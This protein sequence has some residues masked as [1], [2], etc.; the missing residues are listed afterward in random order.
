MIEEVV[1]FVRARVADDI[2]LASDAGGRTWHRPDDEWSP[3]L[4]ENCRGEVVSDGE[5]APTATQAR[6][7]VRHDPQ[8]AL[9]QCRALNRLAAVATDGD[10]ISN[11]LAMVLVD[12]ARIWQEH[13]DFRDEW[14][15]HPAA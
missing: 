8:H 2:E 3:G 14:S 12:A 13:P 10:P 15:S 1:A 7:I 11:A 4:I 5:R 6:H 9:R